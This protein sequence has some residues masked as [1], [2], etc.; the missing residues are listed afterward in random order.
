PSQGALGGAH[1]L[2]IEVE[3]RLGGGRAQILRLSV[4]LE[5]ERRLGGGRAQILR[6]S[7]PLEVERHAADR[8]RRALERRLALG[9]GRLRRLP[10]R[11]E[12]VRREG[13]GHLRRLELQGTGGRAELARGRAKLRG[14]V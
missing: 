2:A 10:V 5:V 1:A 3:R 7:V 6:L 14:G 13:R 9:F 4:P 12:F 11:G 8:R